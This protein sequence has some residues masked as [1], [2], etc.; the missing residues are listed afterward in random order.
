M[1]QETAPVSSSSR[2]LAWMEAV[3]LIPHLPASRAPLQRKTTRR[4]PAPQATRPARGTGRAGDAD[5]AQVGRV[6]QAGRPGEVGAGVG[7]PV[8]EEA[9]DPGLEGSGARSRRH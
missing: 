3:W 2:A 5:G 6:A 7:A 4:R 1:T 8:A 9:K